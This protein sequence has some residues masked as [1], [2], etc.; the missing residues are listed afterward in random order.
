MNRSVLREDDFI[1]DTC[2]L[3]L[4]EFALIG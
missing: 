2:T 3:R 4:A 1:A